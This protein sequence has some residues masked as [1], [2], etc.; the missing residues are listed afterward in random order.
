M[1][2]APSQ[3]FVP[4]DASATVDRIAERQNLFVATIIVGIVSEFLFVSVI[5]LLY[6]LFKPVDDVLAGLMLLSIMLQAPLAFLGMANEVATLQFIRGGEFLQV[7]DEHQRDALIMFLVYVDRQGVL[8]SQVFW[9][10]WLLPLGALVFRSKMIPR[11]LGIWLVLNGLAYIALSVIGLARPELRAS[12][13]SLA[14]PLMFGELALA[15]WLL[16]MGVKLRSPSEAA[17]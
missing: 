8:V 7:F 5:L 15:L 4:G 10:V 2:Y 1:F 3:L 12:A 11:F 13:F 16:I 14:T 6:R 9:G 17:K